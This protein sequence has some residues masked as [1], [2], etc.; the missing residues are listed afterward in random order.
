MQEILRDRAIN[1]GYIYLSSV[2]K[3][4]L[5]LIEIMSCGKLAKVKIK[6]NSKKALIV[7]KALYPPIINFT[8]PLNP[9]AMLMI[10]SKTQVQLR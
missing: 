2:L 8:L 4:F 5:S 7:R 1:R 9:V 6:A 3:T 10:N